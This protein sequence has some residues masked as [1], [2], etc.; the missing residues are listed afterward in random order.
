MAIAAG[1]AA[2][3]N[4]SHVAVRAVGLAPPRRAAAHEPRRGGLDDAVAD[5]PHGQEAADLPEAPAELACAG[6]PAAPTTNQMSREANRKIRA[7]ASTLTARLFENM[8]LN[9]AFAFGR[10]SVAV[11]QPRHG[12]SDGERRSAARIAQRGLEAEQRQQQA[13][14]EEADALERV[15]RAGQDRHPPE[16]RGWR[17]LGHDEL[18]GAL[19]AHLREVLG[20]A[21]QRLRGHHVGDDEPRRGREGEHAERDDLDRRGPSNSVVLQPEARGEPAADEVRDDAED[22]VEQEQ[23]RDLRTGV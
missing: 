21:R 20:D 13:A 11:H 14:E 5:H 9:F 6:T 19:G 18:D 2:S 17:V 22:L 23:E 1:N 3:T 4:A 10:P 15:L 12:T 7:A 8:W 16:E